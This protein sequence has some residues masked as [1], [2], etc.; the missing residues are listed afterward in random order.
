MYRRSIKYY[1]IRYNAFIGD[2]NSSA[3]S[4]INKEGPYVTMAFV[5]KEQRYYTGFPECVKD[6][7]F[8][9]FSKLG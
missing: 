6:E 3:Y 9:L 2:G 1:N 7:N 4:T 5:C 8:T